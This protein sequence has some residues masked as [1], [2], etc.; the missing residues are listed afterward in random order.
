MKLCLV[1][2]A[3]FLLEA[4]SAR[5]ILQAIR[6]NRKRTNKKQTRRL[7][8]PRPFMCQAPQSRLDE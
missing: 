6:D 7:K 3:A 1:H 2:A 5:R 4:H 8:H